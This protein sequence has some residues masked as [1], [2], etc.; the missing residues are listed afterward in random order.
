MQKMLVVCPTFGRPKIIN[1]MYDSYM[2][3]T[4]KADL[5]IIGDKRDPKAKDYT[6]SMSQVNGLKVTDIYN[7]AWNKKK[8]EYKYFMQVNDDMVFETRHWDEIVI[9]KLEENQGFGVAYCHDGMGNEKTNLPTAPI[10]S[11]ELLEIC[12]WFQLPTLK[13]LYG[14]RVFQIIGERLNRLFFCKD[15]MIRH[16][17]FMN[18]RAVKDDTYKKSNADDIYKQDEKAY[19]DFIK[20]DLQRIVNLSNERIKKC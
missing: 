16:N 5:W 8:S 7:I 14:D 18:N 9:N 1:H 2:D 3:C 11:N 10:I 13:H 6:V 15:V 19:R 12:G 20:T 17:H 4:K